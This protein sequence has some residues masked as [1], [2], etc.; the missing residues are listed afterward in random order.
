MKA[1]DKIT[2]FYKKLI[3]DGMQK[4]GVEYVSY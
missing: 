2:T 4:V 3:R 1:Y